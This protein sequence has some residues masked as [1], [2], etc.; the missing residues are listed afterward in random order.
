LIGQ[1]NDV[2][3]TQKR[4]QQKEVDLAGEQ[5]LQADL[6]KQTGQLSAD[7]D[8]RQMTADQLDQRLAD[9]Q[10]QNDRLAATNAQEKQKTAQMRAAIANYRAQLAEL[11]RNPPADPKVLADK[12]AALKADVKRRIAAHLP[13]GAPQTADP[14]AAAP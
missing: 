4:V 1:Y 9:L 2:E 7:L 12:V 3:A 13:Q 11:K 5:A 14:A 8:N 6:R 10:Q